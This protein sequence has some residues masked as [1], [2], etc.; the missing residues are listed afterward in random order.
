MPEHL[1]KKMYPTGAVAPKLYGLPKIHRRERIL[2]PLVGNSPHLQNTGDFVE[3]MKGITLYAGEC[4]TSYDVSALFTFVP[5]DP[6]INIIRR[7]LELD[8]ELHSRTT[9]KVRADYQPTGVLFK[10]HLFPVPGQVLWTASR[11]R[12]GV[13]HQPHCGQ[14]IYW[15]LWD[16][17][18]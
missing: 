3:Q 18:L 9:V 10:D 4:I 1:Y 15:G 11:S 17:G 13:S 7:R 2:R 16:Q 14:P 8:Q 6:A 5:I 12:Y